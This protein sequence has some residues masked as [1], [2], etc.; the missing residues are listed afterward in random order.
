MCYFYL[1]AGSLPHLDRYF[2]KC[3]QVNSCSASLANPYPG[4]ILLEAER[5]YARIL[6]KTGVHW[7][8][9]LT[10]KPAVPLHPERVQYSGVDGSNLGDAGA[11]SGKAFTYRSSSWKAWASKAGGGNLLVRYFFNVGDHK[12]F[13][14]EDWD[15]IMGIRIKRRPL[16]LLT[17][18]KSEM[19]M[20]PLM[21]GDERH[22]QERS[23]PFL[24]ARLAL[25]YHN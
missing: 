25:V 13:A 2:G 18:P 10:S 17:G 23:D 24:F 7:V 20:A 1:R 11:Q 5:W 14:G 19:D 15:L 12:E 6:G 9:S 8:A 21:E 16:L 4:T 3:S 22:E